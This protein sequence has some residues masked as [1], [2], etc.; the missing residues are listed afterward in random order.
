MKF[1]NGFRTLN[2][3]DGSQKFTEAVYEIMEIFDWIEKNQINYI[4][5]LQ[6]LLRNDV[7]LYSLTFSVLF[8]V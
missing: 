1:I 3:T 5:Y 7:K 8:F 4:E 2:T 6:K